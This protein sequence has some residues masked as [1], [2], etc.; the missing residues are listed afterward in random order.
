M[1]PKTA[2][3]LILGTYW[4]LMGLGILID[5]AH[6]RYRHIRLRRFRAAKAR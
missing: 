6:I 2:Y 1:D 4:I 5:L 3:L